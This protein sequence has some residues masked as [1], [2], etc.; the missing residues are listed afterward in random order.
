[1]ELQIQ[2]LEANLNKTQGKQVEALRHA[3]LKKDE[4]LRQSYE[5]GTIAFDDI[6][7]DLVNGRTSTNLGSSWGAGMAAGIYGTG[8]GGADPTGEGNQRITDE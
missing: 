3:A 4:L 6:E 7:V 1:M 5:D 2:E 8:E